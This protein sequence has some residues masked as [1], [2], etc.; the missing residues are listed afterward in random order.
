MDQQV[1][2]YKLPQ[3]DDD[4][5]DYNE[6]IQQDEGEGDSDYA[7]GFEQEE[8]KKGAKYEGRQV[9]ISISQGNEK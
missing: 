7:E 3:S 9:N 5:E 2:S 4:Y 1:G 6:E 8:E